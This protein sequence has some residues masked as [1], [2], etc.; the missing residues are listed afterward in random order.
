M[1]GDQ[2]SAV[3]KYSILVGQAGGCDCASRTPL[4]KR[5]SGQA[6]PKDSHLRNFREGRRDASVDVIVEASNDELFL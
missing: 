3:Q 6:R 2:A 4:P 1:S 5:L